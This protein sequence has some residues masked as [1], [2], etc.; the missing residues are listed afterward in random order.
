M[1]KT[2]I[3]ILITILSVE[4]SFSQ[5]VYNSTDFANIGDSVH[6]SKAKTGLNGFDFIQ[7]GANHFWNYDTLPYSTQSDAKWI[8]PLTAGYKATWCLTN[9]IIFGCNS[10]FG[11]GVFI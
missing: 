1:K 3:L 7:T 4:I 6:V 11:A 10:Q 9:S 8:D 5:T 2:I